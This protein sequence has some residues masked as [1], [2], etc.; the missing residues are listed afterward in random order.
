MARFIFFLLLLVTTLP[1]H[2]LAE[3]MP[4]FAPGFEPKFE[5]ISGVQ[6]Y[7]SSNGV[8]ELVMNIPEGKWNLQKGGHVLWSK[9]LP[10][11]PGAAAISDD[12]EL[13]T[14]PIWQFVDEVNSYC[15]GIVFYNKN[16]EPGRIL[17]FLDGWR[18]LLLSLDHIAISPDGKMIVIG[19]DEKAK[20]SVTMINGEDGKKSW[21]ITAGYGIIDAIRMTAKGA[22]TLVATHNRRDMEFVLLDH[23]GN[24]VWTMK[25]AGNFSTGIR[26]YVR[27]DKDEKGFFVYNLSARRF[28]RNLIPVPKRSVP[29]PS[30]SVD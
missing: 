8:Y 12:G 7:A 30:A 27:F 29:K 20:S 10:S 4:R 13:I 19:S 23:E 17:N 21:S 3:L 14:Q 5:K 6:T 11:Q 16:G 2:G 22:Y 9:N 18:S 28:Q 24:P 25:I 15:S 1:Q 26:N